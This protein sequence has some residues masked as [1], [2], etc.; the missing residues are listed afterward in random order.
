[1]HQQTFTSDFFKFLRIIISQLIC[2]KFEEPN[3]TDV[4]YPAF[5]QAI[6]MDYRCTKDPKEEAKEKKDAWPTTPRS[7]KLHPELVDIPKL[8]ERLQ[9]EVLDILNESF[10]HQLAQSL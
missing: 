8:L 3:G 1:M 7:P 4:N 2:K 9:C 6:D 5:V 10:K